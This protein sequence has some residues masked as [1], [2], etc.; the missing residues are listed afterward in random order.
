M[1]LARVDPEE[2]QERT[3]L[4]GSSTGCTGPG[5]RRLRY[6]LL[7]GDADVMPVRYMVLDRVTPPRST[8]PSIRR[9]SITPTSPGTTAASTTGTPARRAFTPAISARSAARR[10]SPIR[11]TSTGSTTGPSWP[12]AAG[13]STRSD[14]V[15]IVAEKTMA[16][17]RAVLFGKGHGLRRAAFV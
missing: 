7:V 13:R 15:R 8:T 9:T 16:E 11:S 12:S 3:T 17:E 2:S 6:V 10:T 1:G 4:S 5:S 14:E